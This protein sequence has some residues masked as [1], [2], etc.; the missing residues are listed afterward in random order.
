[1]NKNSLRKSKIVGMAFS[2]SLLCGTSFITNAAT[3]VPPTAVPAASAPTSEAAQEAVRQEYTKVRAEYEKLHL[4][5]H[6]TTREWVKLRPTQRPEVRSQSTA[7]LD[8]WK[9]VK[10]SESDYANSVKAY[11]AHPSEESYNAVR[12][13]SE[14]TTHGI[15]A[16]RQILDT[17]QQ[18]L[19]VV[20]QTDPAVSPAKPA[21]KKKDLA[22]SISY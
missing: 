3:A 19:K 11:L 8:A 21:A 6:D 13:A 2:V 22:A 20:L 5:H 7:A 12:T 10:D 14:K 15:Q 4:F 17:F 1:M 16:A 18:Q 9:H